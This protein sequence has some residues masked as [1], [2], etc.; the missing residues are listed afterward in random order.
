MALE[1]TGNAVPA[2]GMLAG[3]HTNDR[4]LLYSTH[5]YIQKGVTLKAGQGVLLLGTLLKQDPASKKYVKAT[6]AAEAQGVLR[7][8]TD[9]GTDAL[10]QVWLGNILY[11]GVLKLS[12]VSA[13]NSGVT[14]TDV[15]GARVNLVEGF[16]KF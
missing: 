5:N 15:L 13:A 3:Q 4:E 1:Y 6:V 12:H 14:L 11:A 10:G 2:P 8:T 9:T 7:K 16:F